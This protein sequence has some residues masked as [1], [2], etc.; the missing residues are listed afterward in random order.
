MASIEA[1]THAWW[2]QQ[3]ELAAELGISFEN[4]RRISDLLSKPPP[5]RVGT[6]LVMNSVA[7]GRAMAIDATMTF[8]A[9]ADG[10]GRKVRRVSNGGGGGGGGELSEAGVAC[11]RGEAFDFMSETSSEEV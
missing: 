6:H 9:S 11:R 5:M 4:W 8:M 7:A 1:A 10:V 2:R 3:A